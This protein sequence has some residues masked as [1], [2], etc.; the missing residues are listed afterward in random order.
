MLPAHRGPR[1]R[2][3]PPTTRQGSGQHNHQ[4]SQQVSVHV[5]TARMHE[6]SLGMPEKITELQKGSEP[7]LR[8]SHRADGGQGA[9]AAQSATLPSTLPGGTSSS[10]SSSLPIRRYRLCRR[11]QAR[12]GTR[13]SPSGGAEKPD[14]TW[15]ETTVE[16]G[17][18]GGQQTIMLHLFTGETLRSLHVNLK[19]GN[20]K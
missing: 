11:Q 14:G 16:A 18:G 19:H 6:V 1:V 5:L 13:G 4:D 15:R 7:S 17:L 3:H 8:R 20:P 9:R 2:R 12:W 10:S